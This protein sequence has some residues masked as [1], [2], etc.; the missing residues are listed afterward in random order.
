MTI[1][2]SLL[3][4]RVYVCVCVFLPLLSSLNSQWAKLVLEEA[5]KEGGLLVNWFHV[6]K[7][8][9]NLHKN[10]ENVPEELF[11]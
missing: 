9:F 5:F 10:E 8:I 4:K 7:P 11:K 2:F 6:P 1:R 3:C